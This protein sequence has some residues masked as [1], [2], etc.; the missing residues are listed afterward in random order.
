MRFIHVL[1]DGHPTW[2]RIEGAAAMEISS[3]P[4]SHNCREIAPFTLAS[5]TPLLPPCEPTKIVCVGKNYKAHIQ[6]LHPNEDLPKEPL[7][8]LK[9]PSAL[10]APGG[11]ILLPPQS[12]RVDYEGELAVV[13]G[14]A[15]SWGNEGAAEQAI[16]GYTLANDV[17]ARDLQKKDSQW[18]RGKG[19]DTFCPVGPWLA[20]ELPPNPT[21]VTRVNGA[22][23]QRAGLDQMIFSP[24]AIV[25][26]VSQVMTLHPG[27]IILTGT[28]EGVAPL[29]EGDVVEVE[30]AGI[31]VLRNSV[32]KRR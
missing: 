2:A 23:R 30:M 20:T 4:W 19:F 27:D 18:T 8:F 29:Q 14:R 26:Y 16:F 24:V 1:K 9:P 17:T 11:V 32:E 12:Q 7:L 25:S 21:I 10:N 13:I 5:G 31:G 28:P 15:L 22:E 6:E 3:A